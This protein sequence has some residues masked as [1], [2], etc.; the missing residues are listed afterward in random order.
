MSL[1]RPPRPLRLRFCSSAGQPR[2]GLWCPGAGSG[3]PQFRQPPAG[4]T[5]P[6]ADHLCGPR[7]PASPR[8]RGAQ[9]AI[10]KWMGTRT[11]VGRLFAR[12]PV[13][14]ELARTPGTC[15]ERIGALSRRRTISSKR[16]RTSLFDL[17]RVVAVE[18][19]RSVFRY[20]LTSLV[21]VFGW[22]NAS[23]RSVGQ[24]TTQVA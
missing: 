20:C 23:V 4:W 13:S 11:L 18:R 22:K 8:P 2:F 16:P 17:V 15:F 12:L 5:Q 7:S 14:R 9:H 24:H 10:C 1:L 6:S 21:H 19:R 3:S